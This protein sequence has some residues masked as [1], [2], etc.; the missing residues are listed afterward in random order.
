MVKYTYYYHQSKYDQQFHS[1][2]NDNLFQEIVDFFIKHGDEQVILRQLKA[3]IKT[4]KN[5]D[6]FLD[7]MIQLNVLS[8]YD[9]HYRLSFPIYDLKDYLV[10]LP[11]T[12]HKCIEEIKK[13]E[14]HYLIAFLGERLWTECETKENYFFGIIDNKNSTSFYT[15]RVIG[16]KELNMVT[17]QTQTENNLSIPTYFYALSLP[18]VPENYHPLQKILGDVNQEYFFGQVKK[19]I[20]K[21]QKNKNSSKRRD[22]FEESLL[23]TKDLTIKNQKI[24][25][26]TPLINKSMIEENNQHSNQ[27]IQSIATLCETYDDINTIALVKKIIFSKILNECFN[28]RNSITY[29]L[30]NDNYIM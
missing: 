29:L 14:F 6:L 11:N 8:R 17:L 16:D 20:K 27:L 30:V 7:K 9:R 23:L 28:G 25:L 13:E 12:V 26:V 2:V 15:K 10:T 19:I 22:I 5:L 1:L 4:E 3:A 21:T 18:K 24:S